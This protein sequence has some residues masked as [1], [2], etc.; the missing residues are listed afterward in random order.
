MFVSAVSDAQSERNRRGEA[1]EDLVVELLKKKNCTITERHRG[2]MG[3]KGE[4]YADINAY[5]D[6][7]RVRIECKVALAWIKDKRY[8]PPIGVGRFVLSNDITP[9]ECYA[10]GVD[11][12][13]DGTLTVDFIKAE[14][15]DEFI[16]VHGAYPKYPI[17]R[18]QAMA[19]IE[20]C[21]ND[22]QT[23]IMPRE[24]LLELMK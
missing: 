7:K 14:D 19:K 6:G 20:R 16:R 13:I 3:E 15:P 24:K 8:N 4:H 5:C 10:F 18:V 21:F 11:D 1:F 23:I 17:D 2:G 22:T 12:Q 9:K